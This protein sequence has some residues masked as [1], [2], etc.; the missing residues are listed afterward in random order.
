M[1][2][3]ENQVSSEAIFETLTAYQKA[4][5]LHA[6][7]ELDVFTAIAEGAN[8]VPALAKRCEAAERGMR[9]LCD[10]LVVERF[11]TKGER[12]YALTD[13]AAMYLDRRSPAYIGSISTF[14]HSPRLHRAFDDVAGAVRQ[15][16]TV[17]NEQGML[18]AENPAWVEFARAMAPLAA[19]QAESI[20]QIFESLSLT[21]GRIL[22]IAAG[23]GRYGIALASRWPETELVFQDWPN[24]LTVAE[25]NAREAGLGDRHRTLAG[26][27]FEVDFGGPYDTILV[28]NFLHH[29]DPQTCVNFL[30]KVYAALHEGGRAVTVEFVVNAD[31]VSPPPPAR[32][33]LV[34]LVSTP[35]GDAYT[36][37]EIEQM[38]TEA[39]FRHTDLYE[40]ENSFQSALF[41]YR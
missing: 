6:A 20:V 25:R 34:M 31:R 22:D 28:T 2:M 13:Q 1:G 30:K 38:F 40:L 33:S 15:G 18:A 4:A 7:I 32:F 27:A 10:F 21:P 9:S 26:D 12:Q 3:R 11:L 24:V 35:Q 39:G 41:S 5:A 19:A 29:F 8:T 23:H 36:Q 17:L 14:L 16:G 37:A